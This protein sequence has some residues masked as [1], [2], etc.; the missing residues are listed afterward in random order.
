MKIAIT[1]LKEVKPGVCLA[2]PD[3]ADEEDVDGTWNIVEVAEAVPPFE[4]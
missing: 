2:D 3:D 4:S 1:L